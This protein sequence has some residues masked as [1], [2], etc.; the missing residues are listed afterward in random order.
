VDDEVAVAVEDRL[1]GPVHEQALGVEALERAVGVLV[2][3]GGHRHQL[4]GPPGRRRQ[5]L[6][7]VARLGAGE[8]GT[9]RGDPPRLRGVGHA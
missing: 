7:D 9:S 3:G 4:V 8:V 2:A 6:P 1:P 5:R